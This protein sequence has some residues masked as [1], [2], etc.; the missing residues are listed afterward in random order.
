[1]SEENEALAELAAG[2]KEA[3]TDRGSDD[4]R[5]AGLALQAVLHFLY[6]EHPELTHQDLH[7]PLA[8]LLVALEALNSGRVSPMLKP[9]WAGNN[10]PFGATFRMAKGFALFAIEQLIEQGIKVKPTCDAVA[11]TWNETLA[12]PKNTAPETIRSWFYRS[13]ALPDDDPERMVLAACQHAVAMYP[14][15]RSRSKEAILDLL[16]RNLRSLGTKTIVEQA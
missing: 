3:L 14:D 1:M 8:D 4:R 9:A 12:A 7:M 11:E 16:S 15:M 5:A 6:D 10:P 2:L 13:D